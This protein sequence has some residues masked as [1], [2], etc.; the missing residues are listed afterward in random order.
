MSD[1]FVEYAS[2]APE[3]DGSYFDGVDRWRG[4]V[5]RKMEGAESALRKATQL[6]S[7]KNPQ[8]ERNLAVVLFWLMR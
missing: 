5:A 8:A 1:Q 3:E 7:V 6:R 2:Q 4:D